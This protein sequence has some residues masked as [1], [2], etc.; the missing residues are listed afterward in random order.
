VSIVVWVTAAPDLFVIQLIRTLGD[1][2]G[3]SMMVG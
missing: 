2:W 1:T 3:Q